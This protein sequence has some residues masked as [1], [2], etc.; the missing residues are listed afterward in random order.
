M[1]R[2]RRFLLPRAAAAADGRFPGTAL[3][4]RRSTS[5]G[6]LVNYGVGQPRQAVGILGLALSRL[7]L[8]GAWRRRSLAPAGSSPPVQILVDLSGASEVLELLE[9]RKGS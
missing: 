9:S 2:T 6:A 3:V 8:K 4:A 7:Q 5:G 1:E